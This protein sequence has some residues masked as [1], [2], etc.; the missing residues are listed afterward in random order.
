MFTQDHREIINDNYWCLSFGERRIWLDGHILIKPV[1]ARAQAALD[2]MRSHTLIYHLTKEDGSKITVCKKMFLHTLGLKTDGTVTEFVKSKLGNTS[3]LTETSDKRGKAEPRNKSDWEKIR[4]HISGYHPQVSHY[5][6]ERTPNRRYLDSNLS[7][8]DM[9]RDYNEK[10]LNVCYSVYRRVFEQ[11][12]IGFGKPSQD[13]C[14][15]CVI[16]N[17]HVAAHND[18]DDKSACETCRKFEQHLSSAENARHAYKDD[19]SAEFPDNTVVFAADMQRVLLLPKMTTK[20]HLFVSRLVV[21]NETFASLTG[22][23][24]YVILWHEGIAGRLGINVASAY[25]KCIN[26]SAKENVIIWADNC[27]GQNKNW[28]LFTAFVMCVNQEWGP[29][30]ITM[31]FF[32]RGHTFMRADNIHGTIGN[33]MKK[34]PEICTFQDFVDLCDRAGKN[35]KPVVM[36]PADFYLLQ[37]G[38]RTRQSKNVDLP[39]ISSLCQVEFRKGRRTLFYKT[40]HVDEDFIEVE[41]LKPKFDIHSFPGAMSEPRGIPATK[42]EKLLKLTN[43]FPPAKKKFWLD[44][45]INNENRDLVEAFD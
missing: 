5:T 43:C 18:D 44:M 29:R 6:R 32:E 28:A 3:S 20:E 38:H 7:I 31:K 30:K 37:D 9:W 35:I 14:D 17:A 34:M 40:K 26:L 39:L 10:N 16:N 24:D 36:H 12:N 2:H 13:E 21:F 8:A 15:V 25:I 45:P 41:F 33:K 19:N 11:E 1:I 4:A 42:R 22:S 27:T 23:E